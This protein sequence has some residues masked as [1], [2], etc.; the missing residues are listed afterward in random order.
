ME[1]KM[2][3][4]F[5]QFDL[6]NTVHTEAIEKVSEWSVECLTMKSYTAAELRQH[7]LGIVAFAEGT[8][9]FLGHVAITEINGINQKKFARLGALAVDGAVQGNGI[10]SGLIG[11][12]MKM[13]PG[14]LPELESYYAYVHPGS[15]K[16]FLENDAEIVGARVPAAPTGCNI[17]V[18][19]SPN[20]GGT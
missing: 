17:I 11:Y 10:G 15:L 5:E 7:P 12:A 19:L 4:K 8:D 1:E 2:K 6:G 9:E 16:P 18:S 13:A 3:Y 14:L 20:N